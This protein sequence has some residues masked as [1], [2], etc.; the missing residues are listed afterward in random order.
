MQANA[1]TYVQQYGKILDVERAQLR[2]NSEW[3]APLT[4][5]DVVKLAATMTLARLLERD[6]FQKRYSENLPIS[7]HEFFYPLMQG[8]DSVALQTDIELGGTDQTFNLLVGRHLQKEYGQEQQVVMTFPL[9]EGLDGV[10]KMSKSLGNYIG[11]CEEPQ[12]MYGKAMSIPDE[13]M[14]RYYELL[15]DLEPVEIEEL[16]AGLAAG[17]VHPRDAKMQLAHCLVRMNHDQAAAEEAE[18][19][20]R[21]VFHKGNLP[22]EMSE[23]V[24]EGTSTASIVRLVAWSRFGGFA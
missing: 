17:S 14:I 13:L 22:D 11:V 6:D 19:N 18:K 8:Y 1:R 4:F 2:F 20:F 21:L 12:E 3:L 5:A 7:L 24:W 16:K 23:M 15:T 9:L 10:Q